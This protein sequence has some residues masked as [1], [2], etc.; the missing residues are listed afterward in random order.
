VNAPLIIAGS[1]GLLAALIHGAAGEVLVVRRLSPGVLAP[2]PFGGPVMTKAM[3][4][5][6]WHITTAAFLT[7][8]LALLISGS[9]LHGDTARAAG[10]V[11][12]AGF[13]GFAAVALGLGA[14]RTRSLRPLL[15]HPG[16]A[17]L[18]LTAV[19]AWWGAL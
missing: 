11:A 18:G 7:L 1:L 15:R 9:V 8:G 13:T 3:I 5:V 4:Q 17:V 10:V 2:S 16:P 6:A 19:L 14:A 12:A